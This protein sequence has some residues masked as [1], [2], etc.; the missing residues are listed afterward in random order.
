MAVRCIEECAEPG[1]DPIVGRVYWVREVNS[2]GGAICFTCY[3]MNRKC[4]DV[5]LSLHRVAHPVWDG[6]VGWH[7]AS[8][9]VPLDG[10]ETFEGETRKVSEGV[11]A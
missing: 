7:C 4:P 2:G 5:G 6:L 8:C 1:V 9:F 3:R 11:D 10:D